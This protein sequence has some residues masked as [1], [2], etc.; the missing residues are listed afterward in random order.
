M[1]GIRPIPAELLMDS[2][3]L[4][5]PS[6]SGF[7]REELTDVRI[8]RVSSITDSAAARVSDCTELVMYFDCVNSSTAGTEFCAG[9]L[10][11]YCGEVFSLIRAELFA[12]EQP[13]HY[14]ITARKTGGEFR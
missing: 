8:L 1:S 7:D 2:A 14:R 4:L 9:Q 12:G 5:T 13:H 10:L 11:E 3:L 6:A